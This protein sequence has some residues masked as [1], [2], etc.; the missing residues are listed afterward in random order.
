MESFYYITD[1]INNILRK[2]I[3]LLLFAILVITFFTRNNFKSV[4]NI[5][6]E[7]LGQ[8]QQIKIEDES[9]IKFIN[10]G[11]LYELTCLY[12]Y[13]INALIVS[14]INYKLFNIEK[15]NKVFPYDLCLIWGSNVSSGI[16]KYKNLRFYQDCRWCFV[17][18]REELKFNW[19][20]FS[21]SHL[22]INNPGLEKR[23]KSLVV[24]DQ[25]RIKGKLVN[26]KAKLTGKLENY[27]ALEYAWNTGVKKSGAG[28]GAC[29]VIYVER[30]D[31]LQKANVISDFLFHFSL[32]GLIILIIWKFIFLF[33]PYKNNS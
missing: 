4:E 6:P 18:W 32:Y 26:V 17:Q 8:P 13:E 19:E 10:N 28:A 23:V 31:I 16:Y 12:D 2:H 33:F 14:K 7:I 27:D 15:F 3:F 21:N 30:V 20:E 24:G 9:L 22:L 1:F 29:K 11:Y 5:R 25:V